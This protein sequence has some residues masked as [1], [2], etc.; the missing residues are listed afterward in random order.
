MALTGRVISP[1]GL[2][3]P[4]VSTPALPAGI[5]GV[6]GNEI[7]VGFGGGSFADYHQPDVYLEY[8]TGQEAFYASFT[9][10]IAKANFLNPSNQGRRA[11][12]TV[13]AG[14]TPNVVQQSPARSQKQ[15]GYTQAIQYFAASNTWQLA[16]P[17]D[18]P[19]SRAKQPSTKFV[20]PFSTAGNIPTRMPWDL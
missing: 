17:T 16:G 7:H 3:G 19:G 12:S 6:R 4:A 13:M 14:Y 11:L 20:S 9:P 15:E 8:G 2:S 5:P 1:G 18:S 10:A